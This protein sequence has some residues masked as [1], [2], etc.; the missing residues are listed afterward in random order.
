MHEAPPK[1]KLQTKKQHKQFL[2]KMHEINPEVTAATPLDCNQTH[3]NL[4]GSGLHAG[5][6]HGPTGKQS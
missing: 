4:P 3:L 6:E 2:A 1:F 5:S